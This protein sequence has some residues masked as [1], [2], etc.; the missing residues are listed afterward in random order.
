MGAGMNSATRCP[1]H[2]DN[3]ALRFAAGGEAALATI[4]HIDGSFSRRL[5]AQL[6]IGRDGS[7]VGSMAD[8]CLEGALV[9]LAQE[10]WA[11]GQPRFVHFGGAGD[12]MDLRLPCGSRL[13]ITLEPKPDM[14]ALA[15]AV[16]ALDARRCAEV[17]VPLADGSF[18]RRPY[19]PELR[20]VAFGTGPELSA[21]ER[22][23]QAHG[24]LVQSLRPHGEGGGEGL[25][26]GQA[27]AMDLDAWSAVVVL[28]HDHEW[29]RAILPAALESDAFYVGAQGGAAAREARAE[30]MADLGLKERAQGR[31]HGPVGLIDRARD[32]AVLALS[33][34]AEI[35][36]AYEA[37]A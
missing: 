2:G 35:A 27:P 36:A 25:S 17:G 6:A 8:G 10:A 3:A 24:A 31:L 12:P 30:L 33:V 19:R 1:N 5:G 37:L 9:A 14:M 22:L 4:T 32:P 23:A 18:M 11:D 21:F 28:F 29:E 7:V 15:A 16:E 26:L 34:L 13:A 20:I